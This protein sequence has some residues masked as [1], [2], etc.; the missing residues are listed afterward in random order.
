MSKEGQSRPQLGPQESRPG[1]PR[2]DPVV[3]APVPSARG[4]EAKVQE[5]LEHL[6]TSPPTEGSVLAFQPG[7]LEGW[8]QEDEGRSAAGAAA[9]GPNLSVDDFAPLLESVLTQEG[10]TMAGQTDTSPAGDPKQL[11]TDAQPIAAFSPGVGFWTAVKRTR[12]TRGTGD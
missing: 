4:G 9:V 11:P 8:G 3:G 6:E 12:A 5:W 2:E 10:L 1:F 7:S